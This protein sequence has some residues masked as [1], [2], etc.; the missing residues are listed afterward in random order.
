MPLS[1]IAVCT[2]CR[3]EFDT[4]E[5]ASV[6]QDPD[7]EIFCSDSCET[8]WLEAAEAAQEYDLAR[9]SGAPVFGP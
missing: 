1:P 3:E 4:V 2:N 8:N 5:Y 7:T 9:W 6:P